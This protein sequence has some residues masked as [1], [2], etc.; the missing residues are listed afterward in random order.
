MLGQMTAAEG[1]EAFKAREEKQLHKLI[2]Q[3][4]NRRDVVVIHSRM[5]KRTTN[6]MGIPDFC[7][8]Y[9]GV[10]YAIEAKA[11]KGKLTAEQMRTLHRMAGNGW[12][13][14]VVFNFDEFKKIIS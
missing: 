7:F 6:A 4:L 2:W 10:P 1:M 9:G 8:V 3:E 13:C 14:H 11:R 5:D 12:H